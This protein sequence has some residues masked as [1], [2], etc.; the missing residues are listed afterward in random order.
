MKVFVS[1]RAR[2]DFS[3]QAAVSAVYDLDDP[4]VRVAF[5]KAL[6][7]ADAFPV[8]VRVDKEVADAIGVGEKVPTQN[9]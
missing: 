5:A 2:E 7:V 1:L 9:R 3:D 8:C 6:A 4:V